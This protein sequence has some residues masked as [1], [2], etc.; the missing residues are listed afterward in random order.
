M[1]LVKVRRHQRAFRNLLLQELDH[2]CELP[3][4]GISSVEVLEAAHIWP[5]SEGG[6]PTLDNGL[7]L[8]RNHHRAMDAGLLR[9]DSEGEFKWVVGISP[10]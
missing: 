7:L 10:F 3:G 5:D 8:C 1:A 4:C 6:E 2:V 9:Y